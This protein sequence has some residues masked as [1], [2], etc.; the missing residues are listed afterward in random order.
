MDYGAIRKTLR[1]ESSGVG[2]QRWRYE[3]AC[4][5]YLCNFKITFLFIRFVDFNF[6]FNYLFQHPVKSNGKGLGRR[7]MYCTY[8]QRTGILRK[9]TAGRSVVS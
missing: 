2:E 5:S 3:F 7:V 4:T 1:G 8:H 9:K 6:I